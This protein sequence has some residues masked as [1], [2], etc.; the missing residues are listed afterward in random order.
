MWRAAASAGWAQARDPVL[1]LGGGAARRQAMPPWPSRGSVGRHGAD[2]DLGQGHGAFLGGPPLCLGSRLAAGRRE[3]GDGLKAADVV[4]AVGA[5][6]FRRPISGN[7]RSRFPASSSASTSTPRPLP[8]RTRPKSPC[9]PTRARPSMRS[10]RRCR[11]RITRRAGSGRTRSASRPISPPSPP[12]TT[13]CCRDLRQVLA[14]IRGGLAGRHHRRQRHDADRLCRER[15]LSGGSAAPVAA[16]GGLRHARLC[17]FPPASGR[18]SL[19][20]DRPVAVL[21][22]DYGFQYTINELGTAAELQQNLVILLVEQRRAG[23]DPRQHGDEGHPAQR[24]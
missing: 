3:G 2:H 11:R 10:G 7:S 22:G 24:R 13:I 21:V 20:P 18:R 5:P 9:S 19:H 14:V 6:S 12:Q 17:P 1:I 16:P 4:L 15:D 23:P 8:A